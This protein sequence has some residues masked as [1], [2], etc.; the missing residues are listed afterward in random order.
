MTG[1]GCAINEDKDKNRLKDKRKTCQYFIWL[2][3]HSFL[4]IQQYRC[5]NPIQ[6]ICIA[7]VCKIIRR[8]RNNTQFVNRLF[9]W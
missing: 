2:T 7:A 8:K 4:S 9:Y 6:Q 1:K 5:A 3:T